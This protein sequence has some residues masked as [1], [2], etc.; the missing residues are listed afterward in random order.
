[1]EPRSRKEE[2]K[3]SYLPSFHHE[4]RDYIHVSWQP[5]AEPLNHSL[6]TRL[7]ITSIQNSPASDKVAGE[8][9][10]LAKK[11]RDILPF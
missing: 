1:M 5:T 4:T 8:S 9:F 10:I 7:T 2:I 6:A 11:E 3:T